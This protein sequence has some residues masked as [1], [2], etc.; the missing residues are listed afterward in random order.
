MTT[1]RILLIE[2]EPG[3]LLTLSDLLATEGYEV[4]TANDGNIGLE[5]ALS[6]P[7]LLIILDV[8]LPGRS[9]FEVCRELRKGGRQTAVLMLTARTQVADRVEGLK[10]GAD[11]YLTKP[12]EPEELLA[13]VEA[14]LRRLNRQR[15]TNPVVTF[16]FGDIEA[17]FSAGVV[18][19][20]G[21]KVSLA[22]R[23]IQLLQ[24]L[25]EH[26]HRVISREELLQKVWG[27]Q[28]LASSR[29]V[30][31]HLAWL[32]HKLESST[33]SPQHF[34]TVRGVGYRFTP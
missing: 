5:K 20:G 29:T 9:G 3:L 17:D 25:V 6:H 15:S 34:H 1:S 7:Y 14:L 26:K 13:R 28:P 19:R 16:R 11:D 30:D 33:Q 2:D 22:S 27:Y 8:M 21:Q 23:E 18:T 32:R 31:L 4:E 24:Y 10:L 12:F